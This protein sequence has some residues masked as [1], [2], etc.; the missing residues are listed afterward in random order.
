MRE[1]NH[2]AVMERQ[3]MSATEL[4]Y[5]ISWW[6]MMTVNV[7]ICLFM[8]WAFVACFTRPESDFRYARKSK[9]FW[10]SVLVVALVIM[11]MT[12]VLPFRLPFQGILTFASAFAA[13]FYLGPEQQWMGPRR[14]RPRK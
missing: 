3:R 4:V 5:N 6:T 12:I 2:V 1:I 8:L 11:V 7:L 10:V 14:R 13:L 9:Q